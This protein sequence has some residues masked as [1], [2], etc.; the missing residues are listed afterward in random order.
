ME[1]FISR[2]L[3]QVEATP[4]RICLKILENNR[5][6]TYAEVL[7]RAELWRAQLRNQGVA[8][9]DRI[10][11][12]HLPSD[13]FICAFL[14]LVSLNATCIL[15]NPSLTQFE[16]EQLMPTACPVGIITSANL[17]KVHSMSIFSQRSVRFIMTTDRN[18]H[19]IDLTEH[20]KRYCFDPLS[21]KKSALTPPHDTSPITCH[22]T[23][24]GLGYPLAVEHH[25]QDYTAAMSLWQSVVGH[26]QH[27]VQYVGLPVYPV[28]GLYSSIIAP[29]AFGSTIVLGDNRSRIMLGET[30]LEHQ[31]TAACIVPDLLIHLIQRQKKL[32]SPLRGKLSTD[33]TLILGGSQ[34]RKPLADEAEEVLGLKAYEGYGATEALPCFVNSRNHH[35]PGSLGKPINGLLTSVVDAFGRELPPNK[36]GEIILKGPTVSKGYAGYPR[37]SA[38]FFTNGWFHTG[39]LGWADDQGN[40]FF[41]GRRFPFSKIGSQMVDLL[42][43]EK[44]ARRHP[45]V[46]RARAAV[47]TD[48]YGASQLK[49]DVQTRRYAMS[50]PKELINFCRAHLSPHKIPKS[51]RIF[52]NER[53]LHT[54]M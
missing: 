24:K 32:N 26:G 42:E 54:T 43:I 52:R 10:L 12:L 27:L 4:D 2:F 1:G 13:D 35:I 19:G 30:F 21:T 36:I 25:Y 6:A 23:Y 28:Y 47:E 53:F 18:V 34:L 46:E 7:H 49:L 50:T 8:S 39:D 3:N 9:G 44:V 17:A 48:E 37:E 22:F 20:L 11:L 31:I 5:V 14:A 40:L 38:Q 16:M 33:F 15:V 41:Y 51:V 45:G 29:L